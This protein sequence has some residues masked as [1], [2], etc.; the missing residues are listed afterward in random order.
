[1]ATEYYIPPNEIGIEDIRRDETEKEILLEKMT[2]YINKN[3]MIKHSIKKGDTVTLIKAYERYR[4]TH[5]YIYD[6]EKVI[7]LEYDIDD[8]GHV[9]K[10]FVVSDS[11]F[12][13]DYW[14]DVIDHN[15]IFFVSKTIIERL[16]FQVRPVQSGS[17]YYSFQAYDFMLDRKFV[18]SYEFKKTKDEDVEQTAKMIQEF[19][20]ALVEKYETVYC[21]LKGKSHTIEIACEGYY[22]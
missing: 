12:S 21:N 22:N 4:N 14:V 13:P 2:K 16:E 10:Q 18:S 8:Y 15:K 11:E 19:K 20:K 3:D 1:M 9:P 5:V 7:E 6:G 17:D